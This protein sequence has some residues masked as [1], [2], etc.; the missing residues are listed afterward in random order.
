M[1]PTLIDRKGFVALISAVIVAAVLLAIAPAA[2][3]SAFW[4]RFDS[5]ARENKNIA[6]QIARGCAEQALLG[7]AR[8]EPVVMWEK[9]ADLQIS[10]ANPYT[11]IAK[12]D[13]KNSFVNLRVDAKLENGKI[14]I[15][16]WREF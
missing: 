3:R 6:L 5:L 10:G 7:V 13:W 15:L 2:A 11:I 14:Q 9:C 12:A 4:A 1:E 8:N 16:D